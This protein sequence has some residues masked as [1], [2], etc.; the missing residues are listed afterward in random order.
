MMHRKKDH[1]IIHQSWVAAPYPPFVAPLRRL[2]K[3][4]LKD[5]HLE[6]HYRG[7]YVLLRVATPPVTIT[8]MMAIIKDEKDDG[9]V[10]QLYQ[11]EDEDHRPGE[12]VVQI[13]RVCILKEPYFKVISDG[14]YGLRVN[15]LSDVIWLSPDDERIPRDWRARI[16]GFEKTAE[17]LKEKGN[18]AL[19][20]GKLN[21]AIKR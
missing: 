4:C 7:F 19:K 11:Q 1:Y 18:L 5:L 8:T 2:K 16:S 12:E 10:F 17:T 15:H 13:Q 14:G 3:L 6:T 20:A 21:I 9:V